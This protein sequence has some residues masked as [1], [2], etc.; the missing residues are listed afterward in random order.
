MNGDYTV[1]D[2]QATQGYISGGC[3]GGW[4]LYVVYEAP[5]EHPIYVTTYNG[6]I[7]VNRRNHSDIVFKDFKTKKKDS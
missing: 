3:S 5:S 2:I 1:A 6:F 4:L 7:Q